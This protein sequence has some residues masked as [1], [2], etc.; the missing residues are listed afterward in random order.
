M[1]MSPRISP[2]Y[3]L[4]GFLYQQPSHGYELNK[5]LEDEFSYIWRVSQSQTYN[6]L[7]RLEHQGYIL[8]TVVEQD[9]LPPRQLLHLS[10]AGI[11]RFN[12][13]LKTPTHCSVHAI[14]VEFI[15]RLYFMNLNNPGKVPEMIEAQAA[16]VNAGLKRLVELRSSLGESQIINRLALDMRIRLL[17]SIVGW[18]EECRKAVSPVGA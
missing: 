2:E 4:L 13:W 18:L 9:K 16:E 14:R 17:T 5:R 7:T 8:S 3:V 1:K 12:D 15:T 11:R 6:I 10:D